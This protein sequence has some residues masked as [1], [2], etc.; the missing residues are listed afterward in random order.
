MITTVAYT[1]DGEV[2]GGTATFTFTGNNVPAGAICKIASSHIYVLASISV[3][4]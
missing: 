4:P 1:G 2:E 3:F